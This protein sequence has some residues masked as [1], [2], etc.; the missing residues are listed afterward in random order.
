M[1]SPYPITR[2]L[3]AHRFVAERWAHEGVRWSAL[4]AVVVGMLAVLT[5]SG[6]TVVHRLHKPTCERVDVRTNVGIDQEGRLCRKR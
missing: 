4:T 1:T 6:W 3:F 2:R 5:L